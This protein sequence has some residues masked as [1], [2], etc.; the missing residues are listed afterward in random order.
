MQKHQDRNIE[1]KN[2]LKQKWQQLKIIA[3]IAYNLGYDTKNCDKHYWIMMIAL[4]VWCKS[5][6]RKLDNS[7]EI[8]HKAIGNA[9]WYYKINSSKW[10]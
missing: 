8:Q 1:F 7:R 6:E 10:S 4:W 5:N 2:T 9:I 3:Y